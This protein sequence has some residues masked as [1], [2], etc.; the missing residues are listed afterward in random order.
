MI[1]S[2][3]EIFGNGN[4]GKIGGIYPPLRIYLDGSLY[5]TVKQ[6]ELSV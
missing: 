1:L 6:L 3:I 4:T 2:L 5:Q